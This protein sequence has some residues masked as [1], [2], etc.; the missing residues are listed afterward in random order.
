MG[1]LIPAPTRFANW[2]VRS[3]LLLM[4]PSAF[5]VR[6]VPMIFLLQVVVPLIAND[7][8]KNWT[9]RAGNDEEDF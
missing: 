6:I 8:G 4:L 5:V 7:E 3:F 1:A 2:P 9:S